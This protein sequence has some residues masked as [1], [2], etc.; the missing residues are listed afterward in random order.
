M[1]EQPSLFLKTLSAKSGQ[2]LEQGPEGAWIR[3]LGMVM[4]VTRKLLKLLPKVIYA[5]QAE[6]DRREVLTVFD[7][8]KGLFKQLEEKMEQAAG[9]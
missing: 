7:Q 3:H 4:G 2:D 6:D 5:G 8:A 9:R 1:I